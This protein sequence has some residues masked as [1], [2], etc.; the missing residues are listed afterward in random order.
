MVEV[1][2]GTGLEVQLGQLWLILAYSGLF[3]RVQRIEGIMSTWIGP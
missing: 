3:W 2:G 1:H